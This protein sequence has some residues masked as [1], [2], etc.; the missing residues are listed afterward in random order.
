MYASQIAK[1]ILQNTG[2]LARSAN[3]RTLKVHK[4]AGSDVWTISSIV[5][6]P[7]RAGTEDE[8]D[9]GIVGVSFD[10]VPLRGVATDDVSI[11][12]EIKDALIDMINDC[13]E[14][15]VPYEHALSI[16]SQDLQPGYGAGRVVGYH[17]FK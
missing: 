10:A 7:G 2:L 13:R 8:F 4:I 5:H 3:S 16:S 12:R 9:D 14:S 17:S 6:N 15:A 11:A 1:I